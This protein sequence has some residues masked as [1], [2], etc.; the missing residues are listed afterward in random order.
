MFVCHDV[1]RVSLLLYAHTSVLYCAQYK[2]VLNSMTSVVFYGA[3]Y[4]IL[5]VDQSN[6]LVFKNWSCNVGNFQEGKYFVLKSVLVL[7]V[8]PF[9]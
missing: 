8:G 9:L 1:F 3:Y 2:N 5:H 7:C 4:T 6:V